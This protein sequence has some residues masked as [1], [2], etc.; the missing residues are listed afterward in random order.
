V[1]GE[2]KERDRCVREQSLQ[3]NELVS[4]VWRPFEKDVLVYGEIVREPREFI[5]WTMKTFD[6][7]G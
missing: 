4:G 7:R 2:V 6:H 3:A 5:P 1:E